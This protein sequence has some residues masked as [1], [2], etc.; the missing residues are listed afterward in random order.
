MSTVFTKFDAKSEAKSDA[1]SEAKSEEKYDAKSEEKYDAKFQ[2]N[3]DV[4]SDEKGDVDGLDNT[5]DWEIRNNFDY[6]RSINRVAKDYFKFNQKEAWDNITRINGRKKRNQN[7]DVKSEGVYGLEDAV[8]Y[9]E[10][11]RDIFTPAVKL[12]QRTEKVLNS[13][14][15][16]NIVGKKVLGNKDLNNIISEYFGGRNRS[17]KSRKKIRK[18]RKRMNKN[19]TRKIK[20]R[21]LKCKKV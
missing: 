7:R 18:S 15:G 4:K 12:I 10:V 20:N 2:A 6:Y 5:D 9:D 11:E 13:A 8:D 21:H 17:K 16:E 3:Y 1:K 19:K 14:E